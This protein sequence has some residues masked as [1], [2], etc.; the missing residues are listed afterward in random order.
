MKDLVKYHSETQLK[1]KD[2]LHF[3]SISS[4]TKNIHIRGRQPTL[5]VNHVICSSNN[6]NNTHITINNISTRSTWETTK[7]NIKYII[8]SKATKHYDNKHNNNNKLKYQSL[9]SVDSDNSDSSSDSISSYE[10][11]KRLF[12]GDDNSFIYPKRKDL[13]LESSEDE[14]TEN[15]SLSLK[16][17]LE[18][19]IDEQLLMIYEKN[20]SNCNYTNGAVFCDQCDMI[21]NYRRQK[22]KTISNTNKND[23][24]S[25][26]NIYIYNV[27]YS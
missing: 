18:S 1:L 4:N 24:R 19:E 23:V 25:V 17:E 22:M 27:I 9:S 8:K 3:H 6:N 5:N 2:L 10:M 26:I 14:S 20:V 12:L 7:H 16:E 11:R 21:R 13:G 15:D